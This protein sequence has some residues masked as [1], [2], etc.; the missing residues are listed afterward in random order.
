MKFTRYKIV[1]LDKQ[2]LTKNI[3]LSLII[4][5]SFLFIG[6]II[7][8]FFINLMPGDPILAYLPIGRP[9]PELYDYWRHELWFD[10]PFIMQVFKYL[11]DLFIGNWGFS[12]SIS[13]RQDVWSLLALRTPRTID[14][15]II[16]TIIGVVIGILIGKI[17]F[18]FRKTREGKVLQGILILCVSIPIFSFGIFLKKYL[19]IDMNMFPVHGYKTSEYGDPE[20]VTGFRIIDA[21]ISGQFYMVTDYLYHLFLPVLC[22]TIATVALIA[23]FTR[24]QM[25]KKENVKSIFSNSMY[26]VWIFTFIFT[27]CIL[28]ETIFGLGGIYETFINAIREADYYV[29]RSSIY[30]IIMIF[31]VVMLISNLIFAILKSSTIAPKNSLKPN[32][33]SE[34][35]NNIDQ[36]EINPEMDFGRK[37]KSYAKHIYKSPFLLIGLI[38]TI[39]VIIIGVFPGLISGYSLEETM[40]MSSDTL[41]PP[42]ETHLLGT[43]QSGLDIFALILWGIQYSLLFSI[44]VV[45]I[46]ILGG[47]IFGMISSL[48]KNVNKVIEI[49]LLLNYAIPPVILILYVLT[50]TGFMVFNITFMIG[51]L[52]IPFFTKIFAYV[53]LKRENIIISLKKVVIYIPLSIG[54]V[55]LFWESIAFLQFFWGYPII[56]LGTQIFDGSTHIQIAPWATF[57]PSIFLFII[58]IGFILLHYGLKDAFNSGLESSRIKSNGI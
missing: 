44:Q 6:L 54:F 42:S 8:F 51:V 30:I 49:L 25:E 11:A 40:T 41:E 21:L 20:F 26:M 45:V 7:S 10:R 15:L 31:V 12:T 43:E 38:L 50:I 4:A 29:L 55:I 5:F 2:V 33:F 16:P 56:P 34:K 39:G 23:Y 52:L 22:L 37:I 48:N 14:L 28:I 53:P 9:N 27:Y 17:S 35:N 58:I 13:P 47:I 19:A 24:S 1:N 36:N 46:G 3:I 18:K 57:W 32:G